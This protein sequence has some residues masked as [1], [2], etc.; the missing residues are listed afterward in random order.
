[1]EISVT[2]DLMFNMKSQIKIFETG[3]NDGIMS[4]NKKFYD[5]ALEQEEISTIFYN[6]RQ[7]VGQKFGFKGEKMLQAKQKSNMNDVNYTDGTYIVI[8]DKY[9]T[10]KDLWEENIPADILIITNKYKNIVVGNQM[11]DCPIVIIEDRKIGAT[12]LAHCGALYINRNLPKQLVE[13]LQ[14]EYNSK[15]DN[16]YVYIGSC[17]KKESYVYNNYPTWATNKALWKDYI[18]KKNNLYYIDLVGAIVNQ[19]NS[20]GIKNIEISPYDTVK[21]DKYYSNSA[22][23]KGNKEKFGQNFVGFFYK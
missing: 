3:I 12:A 19:L 21:S 1:M 17:A 6:T 5:E 14:K 23:S 10:K 2:S 11:A 16:L 8:S 13:S 18:I 4:R 7:K 9:L 15:I 20:K 22:S